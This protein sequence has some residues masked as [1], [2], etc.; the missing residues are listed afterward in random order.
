MSLLTR[1]FGDPNVRVIKTLEPIVRGIRQHA[2]G[3]MALRDEQLKAKTEEFKRR[4]QK[5][6]ESLDDVLPEAFAVVVEA[7]RRLKKER[8]TW[9]ARGIETPWD[10]EPFDVQLI[11]GIVLHQGKISEMRT[12]EGKTLVAVAPAYLNA[13]AGQGVHIVTVNEY[14]AQRDAEWMGGIYSF[15]GLTVG[16]TLHAQTPDEKREAYAADITYGTNNEFGFDY[17]R[18]NMVHDLKAAAQRTLTYAI[19]DEVDSILI[20]EARTPLIISAPAAESTDLYRQMATL[21]TQLQENRDYN[22]HEK[23]KAVTLSE[24]GI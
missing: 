21:A 15:L 9:N 19:V 4:I 23:L 7:M 6:N 16:K 12:G 17:L 5:N 22:V 10:M 13:L 1:V 14:L 11:G 2:N 20:D 18:D 24:E 3:L 8:A